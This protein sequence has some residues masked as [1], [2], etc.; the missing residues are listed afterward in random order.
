MRNNKK[1]IITGIIIFLVTLIAGFSITAISFNLFEVLTRNQMRALFAFDI[2]SLLMVGACVLLFTQSR[3]SRQ[4]KEK[5]LVE[6]HNKRVERR[7]NELREIEIIIA[8]NK[9]AA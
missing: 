1:Q 4:V 6:N 5:R 7:N 8:K 9:F 3:K 2:I